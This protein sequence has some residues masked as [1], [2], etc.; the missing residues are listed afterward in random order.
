MK[1]SDTI[2]KFIADRLAD[3][4]AD[5]IKTFAPGPGGVG[6]SA[7]TT[8]EVPQEYETLELA[9]AANP[10]VHRSVNVIANTLSDVPLKVYREI[11]Q[12]ADVERKEVFVGQHPLADILWSPS[13]R[14]SGTDFIRRLASFFT[15]NGEAIVFV[16]NGTSGEA[17]GGAPERLQIL[18]SRFI[19]EVRVSPFGVISEYVYSQMGQR[20]LIDPEFIVHPMNFNP[21]DDTR[22]LS[23]IKI[24]QNPILMEYYLMRHNSNFFKNGATPTGVLSADGFLGDAEK[25]R[26]LEAWYKAYGATGKRSRGI[27]HL[28]AATKFQETGSTAKDGEFIGLD[29]MAMTEILAVFGVPP[30]LVGD[31]D[32]ANFANSTQ[33]VQGFYQYTIKPTAALIANA[34]NNQFVD[35][36]YGADSGLYVEFDF[37][38]VT[39]LQED[40]LR[41]AQINSIYVRDKIKTRNEVRFELNLE[42]VEGGDDFPEDPFSLFGSSLSVGGPTAVKGNRGGMSRD[43]HWRAFSEGLEK[44]EKTFAGAMRSYFRQQAERIE[45]AINRVFTLAMSGAGVPDSVRAIAP[46]DLFAIFDL[47]LENAELRALITPLIRRMIDA[48]GA[49]AAKLAGDAS[50]WNVVDPRVSNLIA[51]KVLK[52]SQV[53]NTTKNMITE[54][55]VDASND[56]LTISETA[57]NIRTMFEDMSTSRSVTIARTEVIGANNGATMEGF[58]QA[59]VE[60]KEWLSSRDADVRESH[61]LMDSEVAAIGAPFSNGL[62]FPGGD[63]PAEEV[64]NCRCSILAILE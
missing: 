21:F 11:G 56:N 36:W 30:F 35:V 42:P 48:A 27:A 58:A 29:K 13:P 61:A 14:M 55:L 6:H 50:V 5:R 26:N 2:A 57:R 63:G 62:M 24:A 40:A 41:N 46:S 43:D 4:I 25:T 37:S 18:K 31:L 12:G 53:N 17:L 59:G 10:W 9:Y 7:V 20:K 44:Q 23:A 1:I 34:L 45:Q 28:D 39:V 38:G 16:E 15:L 47:D 52:I 54:I 22:G 60:K 33:Q 64:V 49:N 3:Q 51:G 19:E 8:S 32:R